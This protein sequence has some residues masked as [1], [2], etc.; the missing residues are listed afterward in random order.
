MRDWRGVSD[1]V[2]HARQLAPKPDL[3]WSC[4][5]KGGANPRALVHAALLVSI[6]GASGGILSEL[7]V[8]DG[9][10]R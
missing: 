6:M 3:A 7:L 8:Q 5:T 1:R 10:N 9:E 4:T 2:K